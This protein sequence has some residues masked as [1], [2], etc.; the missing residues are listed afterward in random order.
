MEPAKRPRIFFIIN[1]LAGGGAERVLLSLAEASL[2]FRDR[3]DLA[4]V[5]LDKEP[6]AY[7]PPEGLRVIQL[8][9]DFK[10]D[11]SI[12]QL[13]GFLR[14]ERPDLTLS[15][16]T[17]ANIASTVLA[18][19][20]GHRAIISERA[21]TSGHF[22]PGLPG[23]IAKGMIR[24]IYPRAD[25]IIAVSRGIADDLAENFGCRP[26]RISTIANP[27]N[28]G[29]IQA[30]AR[31]EPEL[32]LPERFI[33][34]VSRLTKGKNVAMAIDAFARSRSGLPLVIL[35][36][37]GEREAL[38]GQIERLDLTDRVLMPGFVANPYA[39]V[40]RADCYLS[41]SNGEGFP[42]GLVEALALGTPAISTN[43]PSGPSEVLADLPREAVNG[44]HEGSYGL[45]VPQNDP[46]RMAAAIDLILTPERS[47]RYR[48]QG[49]E[50][51]AHYSVDRAR[52]RYW[53]AIDGIL[54]VARP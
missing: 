53:E 32:P 28:L 6:W 30:M 47:A 22:R 33:V 54:A 26:D 7:Q 29:R 2:I 27:V 35:G 12:R 17:R 14:T 25:H 20:M 16:L 23:R 10:L 37:G 36:E 21:N 11:R 3:I 9:S 38:I 49:P 8:D 42:N 34:V 50:R 40:G 4:L 51:A 46:D 48:S 39:I 18:R 1:S 31:M 15:F 19:L 52:D 45:L 13:H 24:A 5:L 41:A 43:C 44:L